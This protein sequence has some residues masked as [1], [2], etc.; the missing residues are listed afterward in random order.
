MNEVHLWTEGMDPKVPRQYR[1]G[2]A[3]VYWGPRTSSCHQDNGKA[4]IM[5]E[6]AFT[7]LEQRNKLEHGY[8]EAEA[9]WSEDKRDNRRSRKQHVAEQG[10]EEEDKEEKGRESNR[11]IE[12]W[13][14]EEGEQDGRTSQRVKVA[15]VE[16]QDKEPRQNHYF[17]W[18]KDL[19]SKMTVH[20]ETAKCEPVQGSM[21]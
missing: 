15:E 13:V 6:M 17:P 4:Q 18:T 5:Q 14:A 16:W 9:A 2:R 12:S 21:T 8:P 1:S 3:G 19:L 11:I 20:I 10:N 7:I